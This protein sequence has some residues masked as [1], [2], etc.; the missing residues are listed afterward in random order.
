[1]IIPSFTH[2]FDRPSKKQRGEMHLPAKE[3]AAT[4]IEQSIGNLKGRANWYT[5]RT[6][7]H[8]FQNSRPLLVTLTSS[9]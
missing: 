7:G 8:K 2:I 6:T 4:S 3:A 1:M 5:A 9:P